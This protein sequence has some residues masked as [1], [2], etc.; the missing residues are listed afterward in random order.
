MSNNPMPDPQ[1]APR[2][3]E[4]AVLLLF[5]PR[6]PQNHRA[7]RTYYVG[8]DYGDLTDVPASLFDDILNGMHDG[9]PADG[10]LFTSTGAHNL[11]PFLQMVWRTSEAF[12]LRDLKKGQRHTP[13][14]RIIQSAAWTLIQ[15]QWAEHLERIFG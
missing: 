15:A 10:L 13:E 7:T 8:A 9:H 12:A 5:D 14:A 6:Q 11:G 2:A 4:P 1:D 3:T